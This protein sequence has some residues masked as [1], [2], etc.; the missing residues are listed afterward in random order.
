LLDSELVV[1]FDDEPES[2]LEIVHVAHAD[3]FSYQT[4][5]TIAPFVVQS[6][7]DACLAAAFVAWTML[8]G[9][10]PFGMAS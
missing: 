5:N 10:E 2:F 4:G 7:D 3:G 8:P 1:P 6:F 9:C